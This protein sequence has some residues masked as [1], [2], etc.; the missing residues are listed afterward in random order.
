M[1]VY[2]WCVCQACCRLL[3]YKKTILDRKSGHNGTVLRRKH[4]SFFMN[5]PWCDVY[6]WKSN[7]N[8]RV[9]LHFV[10]V[11]FYFLGKQYFFHQY[12][13][14]GMISK[15]RKKFKS[16]DGFISSIYLSRQK[17]AAGFTKVAVLLD[18]WLVAQNAIIEF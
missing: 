16:H 1:D 14:N 15:I 17:N 4:W 5:G 11:F 9:F 6:V 18:I 10:M 12:L 3:P 8:L 7:N 2:K 13:I